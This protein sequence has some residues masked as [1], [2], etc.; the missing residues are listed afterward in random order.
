MFGL[1]EFKL[2]LLTTLPLCRGIFT[3]S[4]EFSKHKRDLLT[5]SH[6]MKCSLC[7]GLTLEQKLLGYRLMSRQE[8]ATR[9]G[10]T[11]MQPQ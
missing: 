11:R 2:L 6:D 5:V 4:K 9:M 1:A 7:M 10:I 8:M 3:V